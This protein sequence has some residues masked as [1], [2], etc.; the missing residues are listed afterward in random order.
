MTTFEDYLE[1]LARQH[2]DILHEH[3][4]K[5]H[6]SYLEDDAQTKLADKMY[7]PC[8]VADSGN[9][10]FNGQPGNILLNTEYSVLFLQHVSD[11][12]NNKEIRKAFADMRRI[13]LDFAAKF[14][15]DKRAM[16]YT[17][18]NRFSLIGGEGQRIYM[19]NNA[20]YGYALLFSADTSFTDN[21]C[22]NVFKD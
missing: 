13:L 19:Q 20:L 1:E 8:V 9:F 10:A 16:K 6:F 14:S 3:K 15:R 17:F 12:G 18:L 5:C 7:Y 21:N 4:D 22:N 2:P 11:T